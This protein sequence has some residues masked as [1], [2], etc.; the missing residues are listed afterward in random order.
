M[1]DPVAE[2][3]NSTRLNFVIPEEDATR[4][5]IEGQHGSLGKG[6]GE[7]FMNAIDGG[8]Q[9]CRIIL[10]KDRFIV[11]DD[12]DGFGGDRADALEKFRAL[13][14][15][16]SERQGSTFGRF[17][18]GRTQVIPWGKVTWE[19]GLNRFVTDYQQYAGFEHSE[20]EEPVEGCVVTG[21]LYKPL[22]SYQLRDV[23]HEVVKNLEFAEGISIELNGNVINDNSQFE[24][25]EVTDLYK[26]RWI[27]KKTNDPF[28]DT[29][30]RI[31]NQGVLVNTLPP[32]SYPMG[33]VVI[34]RKAIK[35]NIARNAPDGQCPVHLAIMERLAEKTRE[36]QKEDRH[37]KQMTLS[38]RNTL[39]SMLD[40]GVEDLVE[41]ID[42]ETPLSSSDLARAKLLRDCRGNFVH[43]DQL[44][45]KPLTIVPDDQIR[46]GES[47]SM[48][49]VAIPV[50]VEEMRFW[51]AFDP[52]QLI[53]RLYGVM[54]QCYT[55]SYGRR[56]YHSPGFLPPLAFEK[57]ALLADTSKR[58]VPT[59]E[60][61][62]SESAA[63]NALQYAA[64]NMAK[65][66]SKFEG[67]ETVRRRVVVG[68]CLTAAGWTDSASFI[69]VERRQLPLANQGLS[70]ACALTMLLLHEYT[71]ND[72]FP[73]CDMHGEAF[74]ERYHEL[75]GAT[76]QNEIVGNVSSSL[77]SR[78]ITE[79]L[80]KG[81][82]LPGSLRSVATEAEQEHFVLDCGIKG[83][84]DFAKTVLNRSNLIVRYGRS[85]VEVTENRES[86]DK[87]SKKIRRFLNYE[88]SRELSI[89]DLEAR[90]KA[91]GLSRAHA[92]WPD[93][94][95][96]YHAKRSKVVA[97]YAHDAGRAAQEHFG[98]SEKAVSKL[99]MSLNKGRSR[100][101]H[102]ELGVAGLI[103]QAIITDEH[104]KCRSWEATTRP[105]LA[106]KIVGSGNFSA[107][108]D[109]WEHRGAGGQQLYN[110]D[111][112]KADPASRREWLKSRVNALLSS[113][114]DEKELGQAKAYLREHVLFD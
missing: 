47:L 42:E 43:F 19:S 111:T 62:A 107:T 13:G 30:C 74:Y 11:V 44:E 88:L 22:T 87:V 18:L 113:F 40:A 57:A 67:V 89:D 99:V 77:K 103:I 20:L 28:S 15:R 114:E 69:A 104:S 72:T 92:F 94:I 21:E 64:D 95:E 101:I 60:L 76:G 16:N 35:V 106:N 102:S 24:W 54:N 58:I 34:A 81:Q 37:S 3:A 53:Q 4:T 82:V 50:T 79:L 31:Y 112:L 32:L 26:I 9:T 41:C 33:A 45:T 10:E 78:Y 83:L 63:R 108:L 23:R 65:R 55:I 73:D 8:A 48:L 25:D 75:T 66:I 56:A 110:G 93:R 14:S 85:K 70:G 109:A 86:A 29:A 17:G 46:I 71:H 7:L 51:G 90:I 96:E 36:L 97:E 27:K 38:L 98:W 49:N 2:T 100:F 52:E 68:E 1:S 5:L 6:L 84:S 61:S 59:K 91:D 80:K 39:V 105:L 12:G